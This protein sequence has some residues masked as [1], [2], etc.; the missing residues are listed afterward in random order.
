MKQHHPI[1][2]ALAKVLFIFVR[3]TLKVRYR[4]SIK[5]SHLLKSS[6]AKL[7]LPNHQS[8]SDPI[9]LFAYLYKYT[10]AVPVMLSA[11]YDMPIAKHIFKAWGAV[12]VSDLEAGSRNTNVLTQIVKSVSK[13]LNNN[14]NVVLYPSGQIVEQGYERILNKQSAQLV[15]KDMPNNTDVIAVRMSGLWGS[16]F[17]KA[18][19][20]KT[21]PFITTISKCI[22]FALSNLLFFMPRRTINIEFINVTK[23]AKAQSNIDKKAFNQYLESIYNSKGEE[24]VSFIKYH[25]L[26]PSLKRE[27]PD[28][29]KENHHNKIDS[30]SIPSTTLNTVKNCISKILNIKADDIKPEHFLQVDLGAD[31]LNIVEII[32]EVENEFSSFSAPQITEIKTVAD[33]CLVALGKFASNSD[34]KPSKLHV[35]VSDIKR[36]AINEHQ[37]IPHQFIK[38]FTK[39]GNDPFCYDAMLGSTSRK[40]FLLKACVVSELI[41]KEIKEEKIGIMLP[42]LQSTTLLLAACYLAGKVPVMLNWT[43]GPKVL[44]HCINTAEI[45]HILSAGAF[46]QKVD[47]QIPDEIKG[48]VVLF[49]EKVKNLSILT[50]LKGA[51]KA[52]LPKLLLSTKNTPE[53]AVILFTSGSEALPKAVPLTHQNIVRN[54]ASVFKMAD[55]DNNLTFLSFLPPF[56]SFG[57]TVLNIL[58]LISAVKVGYTP[59]PT[60]AREV[61]RIMK[62]IKA[63]ILVGTPGFL[64][65]LL[66]EGSSYEFKSVKYAISG[67][68]A[69]PTTL[70]EQFESVTNNGLILE[71]YGITECAPVLTLNPQQKQ[72]TNSVGRILPD[73]SAKILDLDTGKVLL[74]N[75]SG[76]I[77]VNGP[78]VFKG[79]INQKELNPFKK[80]DGEQYYRTGDIGYLDEDGYLFITGRLKRF[81]KIAGEMISLP[82][83]EKI[84]LNKYGSSE[85]QL[86]AVEGTDRT[87]SPKITLFT[88]TP[89]DLQEANAYLLKN[90]VAPI[91]KIK[92]VVPID[93]IPVLGT[94]KAD[95]KVLKALLEKEL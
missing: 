47:E 17:S 72:K 3:W 56:H 40:E 10:T 95:Y 90:G 50:K 8:I 57:F 2:T 87:P 51:A 83:I 76:M 43:V 35:D 6:N 16:R 20:G 54:L 49:E 88:K 41:K 12:R 13:G 24:K 74:T 15:V 71:G 66:S 18:W 89:I 48:M 44:L 5:D 77:Y 28:S 52:K 39:N 46:I 64:K 69:M 55:M 34:L 70:K 85:E 36:L 61:L 81:I 63:N 68:E 75:E 14:K 67:A 80:I 59:N 65:L 26:A 73:I 19:L 31:S 38:S 25:F 84:L 1:I 37:S 4:V 92:D 53:T 58:P 29:I 94:G 22:L 79:Y 30:N 9:L 11:Y 82:F 62:H 33:L 91:A 42:A 27:L 7:I 21:P 93:E 23:D 78:N 86:L 32:S 45:K 60:D